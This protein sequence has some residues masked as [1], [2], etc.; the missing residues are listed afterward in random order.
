MTTP[1]PQ[2]RPPMSLFTID[3]ARRKLLT[4][5]PHAGSALLRFQRLQVWVVDPDAS[6]EPDA[7]AVGLLITQESIVKKEDLAPAYGALSAAFRFQGGTRIE[8]QS[9]AQLDR[10]ELGDYSRLNLHRMR[11]RELFEPAL[12][13][14]LKA[15]QEAGLCRTE[16]QDLQ[17]DTLLSE[18]QASASVAL[19]TAHFAHV[20]GESKFTPLP[21]SCLA[22]AESGM[23]LKMPK[24]AIPAPHVSD[25]VLERS[26]DA[27]LLG[28]QGNDIGNSSFSSALRQ[29]LTCSELGSVASRRA[30]ISQQLLEMGPQCDRAS[31][32][33]NLL[34]SFAIELHARGTPGHGQLDVDSPRAYLNAISRAFLDQFGSV[35]VL[36]SNAKDY[37]ERMKAVSLACPDSKG[38]AAL[39]ALHRFLRSW[40]LA[41]ELERGFFGDASETRVSANRLWPHEIA[42]IR[43]WLADAEQTRLIESVSCAFA[44]GSSAPIRIGELLWLRLEGIRMSDTSIELDIAPLLSDPTL[45]STESRR[46]LL[47]TDP[48]CVAVIRKRVQRRREESSASAKLRGEPTGDLVE[49]YLFGNPNLPGQLFQIGAMT[50]LLN[51]LL[52]AVT[53]D[54]SIGFH[55]LR[56]T[57]ASPYIHAVLSQ[58][59]A[60]TAR[61]DCN[62]IDVWGSTM[63]HSSGQTALDRYTHEFESALRRHQDA[64]FFAHYQPTVRVVEFWTKVSNST[65][66]QRVHRAA[67]SDRCLIGNR[68]LHNAALELNLPT[69]AA[70]IEF[71]PSCIPI[72]PA[73]AKPLSISTVAAALSDLSSGIEMA[74]TQMRQDLPPGDIER[75]CAIVG[76][77]SDRLTGR[78]TRTQSDVAAGV[79]ALID[80]G[81]T[82]G[83]SPDF[84]RI[85]QPRWANLLLSMDSTKDPSLLDE[86]TDYWLSNVQGQ[87]LALAPSMRL[88]SFLVVLRSSQLNLQLM[89]IHVNGLL[90]QLSEV[91]QNHLLQIE[92]IFEGSFGQPVSCVHMTKRGGRPRFY[93]VVSS[94]VGT[95]EDASRQGAGQSIAGLNCIFL[96][97]HV[98]AQ[99]NKG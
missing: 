75:I 4:L 7:R 61:S 89:Q 83:F 58:S 48:E 82:L 51:R 91:Q 57:L 78:R 90:H 10:R 96:A 71:A 44:I 11:G 45:K 64:N 32:A 95:S 33:A 97:A 50:L 38:R 16:P 3:A 99:I 86:G 70:G 39:V 2:R 13:R 77:L 47:I 21:R 65:L 56:H 25:R 92:I 42:C 81:K 19:P 20:M 74:Q 94:T 27:A 30:L 53:G 26:L 60:V 43:L 87:H 98:A 23:A 80:S 73:A 66:R 35:N 34:L 5:A 62:P 18:A 85:S 52:K 29:A 12:M 9:D 49:G 76:C 54:P 63:G 22:R 28:L 36:S 59:G 14:F 31:V 41:P 17:L 93:L 69:A 88:K 68:C 1:N 79:E 6:L 40:D 8:W 67:P 46:R 55:I 84:R 15:A 24:H 37:T 72:V